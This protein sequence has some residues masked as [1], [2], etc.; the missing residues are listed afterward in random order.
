MLSFQSI[1]DKA[2][3]AA[4]RAQPPQDPYAL[5]EFQRRQRM[6]PGLVGRTKTFQGSM[7]FT[8]TA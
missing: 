6:R 8:T 3:P 7:S 1:R 5:A 4:P 2:G